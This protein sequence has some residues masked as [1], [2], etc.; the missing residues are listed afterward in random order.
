MYSQIF[1]ITPEVERELEKKNQDKMQMESAGK[2]SQLMEGEGSDKPL[3]TPLAKQ[4][5]QPRTLHMICEYCL[6]P[7]HL[8]SNCG[9]LM[10]YVFCAGPDII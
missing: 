4:P 8:Q 10:N 3:D 7:G 1:T 2:P 5:L 6:K 9:K